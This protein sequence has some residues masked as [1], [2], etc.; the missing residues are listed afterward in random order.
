VQFIF[1]ATYAVALHQGTFASL[2]ETYSR[3]ARD[4]I[5]SQGATMAAEPSAEIYLTPPER[6]LNQPGLTEVLL[7]IRVVKGR[8]S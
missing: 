6:T 7:P 4:F 3:L 2:E 8:A 5:P 1:G